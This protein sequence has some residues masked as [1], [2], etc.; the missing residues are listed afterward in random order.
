KLKKLKNSTESTSTRSPDSIELESLILDEEILK[1][2]LQKR[3]DNNSTEVV[4]KTD[5][6]KNASEIT[7]SSK[8][9][10]EV[11]IKEETTVVN[12]LL[13][14]NSTASSDAPVAKK[15]DSRK[16]LKNLEASS[17]IQNIHS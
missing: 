17:E 10:E 1:N 15:L 6:P 9:E 2:V 4:E 7:S 3:A 8:S 5:A 12:E 11:E 14:D 13:S 16:A